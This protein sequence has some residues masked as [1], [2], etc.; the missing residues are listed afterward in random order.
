[1]QKTEITC[2]GCGKDLTY[3][4]NCVDYR[5]ALYNENIQ[6]R[7]V[8]VT[9]MMKRPR[10]KRDAHFCGVRCLRLWLDKNHPIKEQS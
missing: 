5:L 6:S 7:G 8:A 9:A 1:M 3:T 10:I 2:D 4:G